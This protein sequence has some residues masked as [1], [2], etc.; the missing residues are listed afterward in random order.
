MSFQDV[1]ATPLSALNSYLERLPARQAELKMLIA[2]AVSIPHMKKEDADNLISRW[3][4][5]AEVAVSNNNVKP[6]SP[7]RLKMM[8][9]GVIENG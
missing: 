4:K 6:A 7:G 3:T 8:G 1:S 2:E 5:E 9:I